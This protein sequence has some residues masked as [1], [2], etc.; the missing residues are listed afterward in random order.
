MHYFHMFSY[1]FPFY[2]QFI[3]LLILISFIH[4]FSSSI[5]ISHVNLCLNV[6]SNFVAFVIIINT[7][8]IVPLY[9]RSTTKCLLEA[10]ET[11]GGV[12]C[13]LRRTGQ[14]RE[15][16]SHAVIHTSRAHMLPTASVTQLTTYGT[17]T[18]LAPLVFK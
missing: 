9:Y 7:I 11:C 5:I 14:E 8:T 4:Y 12:A 13:V 1:F 18:L 16:R 6:F 15:G 10:L 3:N 2:L 17:H